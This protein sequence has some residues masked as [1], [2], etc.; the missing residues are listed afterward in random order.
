MT[1]QCLLLH[2][3]SVLRLRL[4]QPTKPSASPI[5]AGSA[6]SI[7]CL[8]ARS[9]SQETGTRSDRLHAF[10]AYDHGGLCERV[11]TA[12]IK[13]IND[14]H[15]GRCISAIVTISRDDFDDTRV[16]VG[17][18]DLDG[19]VVIVSDTS[20][21]P[22][23]TIICNPEAVAA[24]HADDSGQVA[25]AVA[26]SEV[27]RVI[28]NSGSNVTQLVFIPAETEPLEPFAVHFRVC[29]PR[30]VLTRIGARVRIIMDALGLDPR[31]RRSGL[32]ISVSE[33][34]ETDLVKRIP[35]PEHGRLGFPHPTTLCGPTADHPRDS[36][37][38]VTAISRAGSQ[39]LQTGLLREASHAALTPIPAGESRCCS[40]GCFVQIGT[41]AGSEVFAGSCG[42]DLREDHIVGP[43]TLEDGS[44]SEAEGGICGVS[45]VPVMIMNPGQGGS[46]PEQECGRF[47]SSVRAMPGT[48]GAE[49]LPLRFCDVLKCIVDFSLFRI[50]GDAPRSDADVFLQPHLACSLPVRDI[51]DMAQPVPCLPPSSG[52]GRYTGRV[53]FH[54]DKERGS[55]QRLLD[56]IG[57][58]EKHMRVHTAGRPG[59]SSTAVEV[60]YVARSVG[61]T[62]KPIRGDSGGPVTQP[63][64]DDSPNLLHSFICAEVQ[65]DPLSLSRELLYTLTPACLVLEAVRARQ[66]APGRV[67]PQGALR[68]VRPAATPC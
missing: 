34:L 2:E 31:G 41:G 35:D 28:L 63:Q 1:T 48:G 43:V 57:F 36:K 30:A 66:G 29:V 45:V 22:A 68:F 10:A 21:A 15:S 17:E 50:I 59:S 55:A 56:V 16:V 44:L 58:A 13:L 11:P 7:E 47:V 40:L 52:P 27:T 61:G 24:A 3:R 9:D 25:L 6:E 37:A 32:H 39:Y 12:N 42:H 14:E 62:A 64:T 8:D 46:P 60:T 18:F 23:M 38:F 4:L 26:H 33:L 5:R 20:I 51:T 54:G 49:Q 53:F 19:Y 65:L 67:L